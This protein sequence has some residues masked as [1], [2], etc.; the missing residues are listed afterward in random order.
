MRPK[1][2]RKLLQC[3][4][5]LGTLGPLAFDGHLPEAQMF[6]ELMQR[7][8]RLLRLVD[9]RQQIEPTRLPWKS[10]APYKKAPLW[11]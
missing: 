1:A 9:A 3:R 10:R 5:D 7:E 11:R 4:A 8:A 6:L 2:Q